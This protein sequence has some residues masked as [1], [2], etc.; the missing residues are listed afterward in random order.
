MPLQ[1]SLGE[2]NTRL[3]SKLLKDR[4]ANQFPFN[5]NQK[6]SLMKLPMSSLRVY[7]T[8]LSEALVISFLFTVYAAAIGLTVKVILL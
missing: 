7:I 8:S 5:P 1:S 3:N 6:K 2:L 4:A